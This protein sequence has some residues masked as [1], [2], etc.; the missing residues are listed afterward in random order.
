[1]RVLILN[2]P[3]LNMLGKREPAVYGPATLEEI[4]GKLGE[5]A[6]SL[7]VDLDFYQSNHEGDLIDRIHNSEGVFDAV[8]FNPGAYAHYSIAI[9]D[10]V[11]SV[12]VPVVEVHMSN[13][14]AREDFRRQLVIAPAAA[15]QISG[16]GV[17]S[18]LLGLRAAC[19]MVKGRKK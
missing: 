16:F 19:N 14:H 10:A 4:N 15:G 9:R 6:G 12:P 3:N 1:M 7:G 17:D 18:Y 11:A 5:L 2:G 13:V 8:V